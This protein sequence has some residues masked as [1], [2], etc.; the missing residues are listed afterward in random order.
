MRHER[1]ATL[2][3]VSARSVEGVCPG[4]C[5]E[6]RSR[7]M[8]EWYRTPLYDVVWYGSIFS[9]VAWYGMVWYGLIFSYMTWYGVVWFSMV[10]S[11][12]VWLD[13]SVSVGRN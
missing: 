6:Q 3:T 9:Y 12:M 11:G 7:G 1:A 5:L 8:V 13:T 2:A 10:R 4:D